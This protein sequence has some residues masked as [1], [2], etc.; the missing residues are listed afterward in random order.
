MVAGMSQCGPRSSMT[1]PIAARHRLSRTQLPPSRLEETNIT[2]AQKIMGS[3]LTNVENSVLRKRLYCRA[4]TNVTAKRK[5]EFFN[6]ALDLNF[7][8]KS[9]IIEPKAFSYFFRLH[10]EMF[11]K[12]ITYT[13]IFSAR[14][15]LDEVGHFLPRFER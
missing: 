4:K 3:G 11:F 5:Y 1:S 10:T 13:A 14:M 2:K 6:S 12:V 7:H 8:R 9:I 15:S